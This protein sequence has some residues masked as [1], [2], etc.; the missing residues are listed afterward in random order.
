MFLWNLDFRIVAPGTE[1]ALFG[2]MNPGWAATPSY[3]ALR[4]MSK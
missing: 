1:Q 3:A 4:D 2:I